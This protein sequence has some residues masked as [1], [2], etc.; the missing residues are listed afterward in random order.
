MEVVVSPCLRTKLL[1]QADTLLAQ[2][3]EIE[4]VRLG[5]K[6]LDELYS[7]HI[8]GAAQCPFRN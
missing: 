4:A 7:A 3:L 1:H 8:R 5:L 2:A 6:L